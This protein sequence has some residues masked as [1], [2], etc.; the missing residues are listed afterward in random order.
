MPGIHPFRLLVAYDGSSFGGDMIEDLRNAGVPAGSRVLVVSVAERWLPPP[1]VYEAVTTPAVARNEKQA[2]RI[3]MRGACQIAAQHPEWTVEHEGHT[4]S[5]ARVIV[6]RA[7]E[8]GA[9]LVVAGS[10]GHG[11]I[12]GVLLGSVSR[13][14]ANEAPC[15]VRISRG[16]RPPDG[17]LRLI[18]AYDANPG[19]AK[20]ADAL[21][22]RPWPGGTE[23][24]VVA[25]AGFG[26]SPLGECRLPV[27][28]RRVEALL[29]PAVEALGAAGLTVRTTI[30]EAD[31]RELLVHEAVRLDAHCIF[32]GCNDHTIVDRLLLGTVSNALISRAPCAVEVVR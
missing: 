32:A 9:E 13:K 18:L 3:A 7:R 14:I 24:Q 26:G 23:V 31:P 8:W 10:L 25:A 29:A 17:L 6:R 28:Q 30:E 16:R 20:A 2:E 22:A 21:A 4:G 1:S 19:A 15:S 5:P 11:A 27:D 12:E